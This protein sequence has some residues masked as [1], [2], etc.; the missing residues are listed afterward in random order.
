MPRARRLPGP[1]IAIAVVLGALGASVGAARADDGANA[2]QQ[3]RWPVGPGASPRME[4]G[5]HSLRLLGTDRFETNLA[6][7][8][9]L[10]GRGGFPFTTSDRTSGGASSLGTASGWWGGRSCPTSVIV[11]AGD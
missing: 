5:A 3:S 6:V 4:G 1:L 8:L 10:R 9:A 7:T 11:V 2:L